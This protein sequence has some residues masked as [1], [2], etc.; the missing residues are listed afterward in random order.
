MNFLWKFLPPVC[1]S[2]GLTDLGQRI[3]CL[4]FYEMGAQNLL[5]P[6]KRLMDAEDAG[7]I[8]LTGHF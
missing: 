4:I 7:N 2:A 1:K 6:K 5:I 3:A 8:R